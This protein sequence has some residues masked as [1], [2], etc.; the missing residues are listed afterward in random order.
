MVKHLDG[1]EVEE[2]KGVDR[3]REGGSKNLNV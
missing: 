3:V 2:W 1:E